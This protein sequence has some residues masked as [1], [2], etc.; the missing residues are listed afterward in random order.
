MNS[1]LNKKWQQAPPINKHE[2]LFNLLLNNR[3]LDTN[4]KVQNY[5]YPKLEDL[6]DPF[7][8][9][10]MDRAVERIVQAVKNEE[11][12]IIFG[13]FDT[14]GITSTVILVSALQELGAQVSYRIPDRAKDSHGLKDYLIDEIAE[15]D[16]KLI[17]SCDCGINETKEVSYAKSLGVDIIITDHHE[18]DPA[19]FPNDAVAVI[20]PS[21][22][23]CPYPDDNL[24]GSGIAFK[25]V[26]A[27][28]YKHFHTSQAREEFLHKFLEINAL[29][30]I[31]DCVPLSGENRTLAKHGL[32]KIKTTKWEGLKKL[33]KHAEIDFKGINEETVGFHIA[34]RLNAASRMGDV[35]TAVQLFLGDKRRHKKIIDDLE[36]LNE[37]RRDL[38][39]EVF[40]ECSKQVVKDRSF[41]L[42]SDTEWIPGILGLVAGRYVD[43]LN[44]P[45]I[46]VRLNEDET[47]SASCRAPEGYSIIEA[48]NSCGHLFDRYGGHD[49]AAGFSMKKEHLTALEESLTQYFQDYEA[50]DLSTQIEAFLRPGLLGFEVVDF[51]KGLSPFGM[52]NPVPVFGFEGVIIIEATQIGAN[53][54]H[55]RIKGQKDEQELDFIG[56]FLG[57]LLDKLPGG[58]KVDILFTIGENYWRGKR[59]L[60][61]RVVDLRGSKK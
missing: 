39:L 61:L 2:E 50:P 33:L 11:R 52:G 26:S 22:S 12:I 27:L 14:D 9:D 28:A 46:A 6:H 60:Q 37:Y 58:S 40:Q 16:V 23:H 13:D 36:K 4:E 48:L 7:E 30:V 20:N 44:V 38:T 53:K 5:L 10:S 15:K 42:F 1:L 29:G 21:L 31:A 3:G 51:L 59:R 45:V 19:R 43:S 18:P 24:S 56:F 49:G 8:M 25:L 32:N 34:P 17:I 41:Q 55:L 57:D 47:V 35:R 54:N